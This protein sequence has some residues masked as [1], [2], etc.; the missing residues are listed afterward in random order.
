MKKLIIIV[1]TIV[2]TAITFA[3]VGIG[4]KTPASSAILDL[5]ASDKAFILPRVA[6]TSAIVAPVNGMM[7]YDIS[8][9]CIKLYQQGVWSNC[10]NVT[11][12][13]INNPSN[14]SAVVS[15]YTCNTASAGTLIVGTPVSGVTQTITANVTTVGTY[16]IS[17]AA[18]G[19]T[20]SSSGTFA[21]AGAQNIVLNAT[22]IPTAIGTNSYTLN[23]TPSCNFSRY[24]SVTGVFAN[25]SGTIKD[26][27]RH[28]LGA[29]TALDPFTYQSGNI[30][31]SLYQW[32]RKTDGHEVRSSTTVAT[33]A[34]NNDATL[35]IEVIGKFILNGNWQTVRSYTLWGD[36]TSSFNPNKGVNDPCPVGYKVPS[37]GQWNGLYIAGFGFGSPAA[38]TQNTWTWTGNGYMVGS[39]L[40]L[41]AAG[42]RLYFSSGALTAV[43]T[44]GL[45]WTSTP[46]N[47]NYEY[48]M[49]FASTHVT[50]N[51]NSSSIG[52][53]YS[54]RCIAE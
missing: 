29:N 13:L 40:Y 50:P 51:N 1:L 53:G 12:G 11:T 52:Y 19:V 15:S 41:P 34:T 23:T 7:I 38:A 10:I 49:F 5:T 4:T 31:G 17:A 30:N 36:G 24:S 8:S 47:T 26:F 25:V 46:V 42:G 16:S 43:G 27:T 33:Q 6:N 48:A 14:G 20:F 45:Y 39:N 35:P 2:Q 3:Q 9:N 44:N 37:Q 21:G 18:N 32:G 28:N 54:I 22:G